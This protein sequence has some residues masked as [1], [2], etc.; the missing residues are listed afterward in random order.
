M[1]TYA[2]LGD[3]IRSCYGEGSLASSTALA[4]TTQGCTG[5]MN[6]TLQLQAPAVI[7][8]FVIKEELSEGA[9]V[10]AHKVLVDGREVFN[11]TAIGRTLIVLLPSNVSAQA[12]IELK[13]T[14]ARALPSF[15]LFAAPDP[16]SCQVAASG[17]GCNLI[18]NTRY[19]GPAFQTLTT[20]TVQKCC[21]AC[22][23][24]KQ[25]AFFTSTR[26]QSGHSQTC[27]LMTAQQGSESATGVIS[28][29]PKGGYGS[30][31]HLWE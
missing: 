14:S 30:G 4:A 15:R 21:E 26:T 29:S 22:A 25:C 17:G 23:S 3:F 31:G 7:D 16:A 9:K 24:H 6:V 13:V 11:G 1:E 20:A 5:C 2:G 12:S 8:R 27:A 28:G 19:K 10:L 18:P